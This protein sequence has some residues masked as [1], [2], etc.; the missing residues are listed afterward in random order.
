MFGGGR[1]WTLDLFVKHI[2]FYRVEPNRIFSTNNASA[3]TSWRQLK[4]RAPRKRKQA[5]EPAIKSLHNELASENKSTEALESTLGPGQCKKDNHESTKKTTEEKSRSK[6][7]KKLPS[8]KFPPSKKATTT[9]TGKT[10]KAS[11]DVKSDDKDS[12]KN[13]D[14][15]VDSRVDFSMWKFHS[16]SYFGCMPGEVTLRMKELSQ[17]GFCYDHIDLLLRRLPPTLQINSKV[18][19]QNI[20][21]FIKW[22]IP[23][24]EFIDTNPEILLLE[25]NQVYCYYFEFGIKIKEIIFLNMCNIN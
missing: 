22:N 17:A 19:Y 3:V 15:E 24:K 7:S 12:L 11:E 23:W 13:E 4:P 8:F 10:K 2:L 14:A 6:Q 5:K 16:A 21:S 1:A 18:V 9:D 25:P 20:N